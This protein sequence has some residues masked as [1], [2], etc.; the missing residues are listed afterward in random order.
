MADT[1]HETVE[2]ALHQAGWEFGV[3]ESEW[4]VISG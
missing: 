1:W 4:Q 3:Q 2:E